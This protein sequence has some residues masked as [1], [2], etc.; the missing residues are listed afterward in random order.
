MLQSLRIRT[1][2]L[3]L[4]TTLVTSLACGLVYYQTA[5]ST[6]RSNLIDNAAMR[7]AAQADSLGM[8][9]RSFLKL[10]QAEAES[11]SVRF[12]DS[13]N[14]MLF[15]REEANR[16]GQSIESIGYVELT[17]RFT[18]SSGKVVDLSADPNF[19]SAV[20]GQTSLTESLSEAGEGE[21]RLI[22]IYHPVRDVKNQVQ[23]V[24]RVSFRLETLFSELTEG[25][26]L[27]STEG[28]FFEEFSLLGGAG[29]VLNPSEVAYPLSIEEKRRIAVALSGADS[30]RLDVQSGML[31]ACQV[32]G[33]SW[34]L[35]HYASTDELFQPLHALL[36]KSIV[37]SL[38]MELA[39]SLLLL[40]LI[41]PPFK[42]IEEIVRT[43]EEVAAGNL[44][45][46]PLPIHVQDEI[47][48]LSVSVNTM[49]SRLRSSFDP[50][51]ALTQQTEY[52]IIV[53]DA[54]YRITEFS[55]SA[56]RMLG[57][58]V[59]EVVGK[60]TPLD[61]SD[62]DDIEAKAKRLSGKLGRSIAPGIDYLNA[63][64]GDRN[65][66]TDERVYVHKSGKPFP[67]LISIS[68]IMDNSGSVT[69]YIGLFRDIS[70]EKRIQSEMLRAKEQAEEANASKGLF[71]ARMSHEIRTPING[72][73]GLAQLMKR[74]SLTDAQRDYMNKI[75]SSS[76]VLLG[77]VNDILDYSKIEAGKFE[78]DRIAFEPDELFRK[79]GDTL[80]FFLGKAQLEMIFDIPE[81]LPERIVGDPFRLEQVLLNL[82]NNAI[83]FTPKGYIHFQVEL[84][85]ALD[86]RVLLEFSIKDTG[87]GISEEQLENLF[88]PFVQADGSIS[89]KYG[90][91][92]LGL[93][94]ADEIIT[95]MGGRLNVESK[96]GAGSRFTF[97]LSFPLA[98]EQER[99]EIPA[100]N[101]EAVVAEPLRIL[102]IERPG[103]PQDT[104]RAMLLPYRVELECADCWKIALEA[105]E[106]NEGGGSGY[107]YIFCNMEMSDM[108]GEETWLRL[109]RLA[110]S[111]RIISMTTPLG[112]N[113]WLRMDERDRPER[114]LIKPINRRALRDVM[115]S[116]ATEEETKR[117]RRESG[118][119]EPV[120]R[121]GEAGNP[122]VLLV[123]DHL[124]NQQIACELLQE[125]G[126][127]VDVAPDGIEALEKVSGRA[128]DVVLMDI[129]MPGLDGYEA[130]MRLRSSFNTWRLPIV[131]M[132]ANARLEDRQRCLNVGMNDVLT[133]PIQSDLLFSVVSRW[134]R[135]ARQ[136]DW[137][138][139]LN[140]VNGKEQILRHMLRSFG[141]EY[142]GF[143]SQ[144]EGKLLEKDWKAAARLLH[145]LKGISGN[146][147]AAAVFVA[148]EKL[149][150]VVLGDR[151][152]DDW[153]TAFDTLSHAL[154]ELLEAI[155]WEQSNTSNFQNIT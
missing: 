20:A 155:E 131:A 124:I 53:T 70:H 40:L 81:T 23:G 17:G 75:A 116:F 55:A 6:V 119:T 101:A 135:H 65:S 110:G 138:D 63:A 59:E 88:Q 133:K 99:T 105:M 112:R 69:G 82:L 139:A 142:N 121:S 44:H 71:L 92:G 24:L 146:L 102:C 108:Y 5:Q 60:L 152:E 31:F 86:R 136:I 137:P 149:E 79:L 48:A 1:W 80:S 72:I 97:V 25:S 144:L 76:E 91:T 34:S 96:L 120:R 61:F 93:V 100:E 7:A 12:G 147:S 11:S 115:D 78:L 128:Y 26:L 10:T 125:A 57:Y 15:L 83:K 73:V 33:T 29:D 148:A 98:S 122:R 104:L 42:R 129:H 68:K 130:T 35:V 109:R 77:I 52:G 134:T 32:P 36:I 30:V 67:I 50:L 87:I 153:K 150:A 141:M 94:I 2:L 9:V 64:I 45:A 103:L 111:A 84:L 16:M 21:E 56:R 28:A 4:A 14:R 140:R 145:T 127:E 126:C 49:V 85:E 74:T 46:P 41:S 27:A 118:K 123:E 43:T 62:P 143:P 22:D 66:Y 8:L 117:I 113:E 37:I 95:L 54:D 154:E 18:L 58:S 39:L 13:F 106:G 3:L 51:K 151:P 19:A 47:G 89:R 38:L 114:T 90:G 107:D 132:T